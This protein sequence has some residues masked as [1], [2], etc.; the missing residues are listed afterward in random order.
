MDVEQGHDRHLRRRVELHVV[1]ET[2]EHRFRVSVSEG[3]N[4]LRRG[5]QKIAR[6]GAGT[7]TF[8]FD[9]THHKFTVNN[10]CMM[11]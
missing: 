8:F 11:Q 10:G 7:V 9:A 3:V 2:N 4:R 6:P 1:T 5:I